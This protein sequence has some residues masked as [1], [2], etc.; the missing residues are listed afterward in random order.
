MY[1]SHNALSASEQS[2]FLLFHLLEHLEVRRVRVRGSCRPVLHFIHSLGGIPQQLH[3]AAAVLPRAFCAAY[4][5][6]QL[7]FAHPLVRPGRII[8]NCRALDKI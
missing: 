1:H 3:N 6:L 8:R 4:M 2:C 5:V 7:I